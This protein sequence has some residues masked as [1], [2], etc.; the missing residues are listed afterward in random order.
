MDTES[1]AGG[2]SRGGTGGDGD[3]GGSAGTVGVCFLLYQRVDVNAG[4]VFALVTGKEG[5]VAAEL[6]VGALIN[7][8]MARLAKSADRKKKK[9][10]NRRGS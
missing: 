1:R 4:R 10:R 7:W 9:S 8:Q 3:G 6:D 5:R 2:R